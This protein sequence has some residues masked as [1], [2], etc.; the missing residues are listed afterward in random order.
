MFS[1][2]SKEVRAKNN[3]Y[4]TIYKSDRFYRWDNPSNDKETHLGPK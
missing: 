1:E 3:N 4:K 2:T